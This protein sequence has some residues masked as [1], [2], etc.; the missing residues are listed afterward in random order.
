MLV[1]K[2]KMSPSSSGKTSYVDSK[3]HEWP[4]GATPFALAYGMEFIIPIEI[5]MPTTKTVVQEQ[6]DK[7]EKLKRQLDWANEKREVVA[8]WI[9]SY[10]QRAIA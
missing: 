1:S 9:A 3:F 8:I 7:D 10:H 6:R 4:I 2:T 5:G